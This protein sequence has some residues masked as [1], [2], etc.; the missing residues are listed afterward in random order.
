MQKLANSAIGGNLLKW[1]RSYLTN[2]CLN[3][4]DIEDT[5]SLFRCCTGVNSVDPAPFL[6]Y[7]SDPLEAPTSSRAAMFADEVG[8]GGR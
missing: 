4:R 1:F 3:W 2:R 5:T 6:L 7:V 8:R